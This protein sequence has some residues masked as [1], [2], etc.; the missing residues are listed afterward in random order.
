[1]RK[2]RKVE[3]VQLAGTLPS[4]WFVVTDGLADMDNPLVPVSL[5][6]ALHLRR[7]DELLHSTARDSGGC[8]V[9][10]RVNGA[11]RT[12]KRYPSRFRL[13]V[14]YGLG[15]CFALDEITGMQ[16][17]VPAPAGSPCG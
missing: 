12:W 2:L 17:F 7:R 13:P 3:I 14:K 15:G 16:W 4:Q 11:C 10:C 9:R 6:V 1:M 5:A 8:P